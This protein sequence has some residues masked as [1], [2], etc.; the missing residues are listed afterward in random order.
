M[1]AFSTWH[2]QLFL[3]CDSLLGSDAFAAS[4]LGP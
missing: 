4:G 3:V 1:N 2:G